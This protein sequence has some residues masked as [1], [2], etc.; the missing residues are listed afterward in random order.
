MVKGL[1]YA[2]EAIIAMLTLVIF[3]FG[4]LQIAD[5][6]Q[7]WT[8]YQREV[9]AQDM[10]Y[11]L[12][13]SGHTS[14]FVSRGET[15]S[16][17]TAMTTISDRGMEVSGLISEVPVTELTIGF[18]A[19]K[20]DERE[21]VNIDTATDPGDSCEGDLGELEA[22]SS[23][24]ILETD[25]GL[26][27]TYGVT[28]YF[29]NTNATGNARPGYDTLWVDNG[30]SCQFGND[31]GPYYLD[32]IFYWGDD[33]TPAQ[34]DYLDFKRID[35][36]SS[37]AEFYEATQPVEILNQ[38]AP[39]P[40]DIKT[41]LKPDMVDEND[42]R[43]NSYDM[44]VFMGSSSGPGDSLDFLDYN[45]G[46]AQDLIKESPMLLLMD[47]QSENDVNNNDFLSK[48]GIAWL[49]TGYKDGYSGNPAQAAFSSES[50]SV[51]VETFYNGLE[52]ETN[53][54]LS[55]PGQAISNK[56]DDVSPA[57][58]IYS[59]QERYDYSS[60]QQNDTSMSSSSTDPVVPETYC[61]DISYTN[62]RPNDQHDLSEGSINFPNHGNVNIKSVKLGQTESFCE[63]QIERG[64]IFDF[65]NRLYLNGETVKIGGIEY[66]VDANVDITQESNCDDWGDCANFIPSNAD[67]ND[68]VELMIT[69]ERLQDIENTERF[70]LGGYQSNYNQ[71]QRKALMST[72]FWLS[73]DERGFEG[74][75]DPEGVDSLSIGNI[76]GP[77]YMPYSLYMRWSQ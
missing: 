47:L 27:S 10:A 73:G 9:A 40:N 4:A 18:Y 50:E 16:I 15:G 55:P 71:D 57:R 54:Q 36:T 29:G 69:R 58:T 30:T 44:T 62:P 66:I 59:N 1:G 38:G 2:L 34:S 48:T 21:T 49:G 68:F 22:F 33:N 72:I 28:L 24:P 42:L 8:Q 26:E 61:G 37:E 23:D 39:G 19:D 6:E 56:S 45:S 77:S 25:G 75:E 32:E 64:I 12:E 41:D 70:A 35:S 46:L 5:F 13:T 11:S 60:L 17:Q 31:E 67:S 3:S 14:N 74:R 43:D 63:N 65:D 76:E 53:F 20:P 52:G 7:D 51:D